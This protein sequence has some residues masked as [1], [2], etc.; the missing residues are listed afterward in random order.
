MQYSLLNTGE[1][2]FITVIVDGSPHVANDSHPRFK[3]IVEK[4]IN[5]DESVVDLFDLSATAHKYFERV[6]ERV[7]V[8][9]GQVYFDGDKVDTSLTKYT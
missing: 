7:T 9:N 2:T 1:E 5:N 8:A 3:E 4:S 6:S